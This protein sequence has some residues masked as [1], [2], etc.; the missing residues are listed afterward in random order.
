MAAGRSARLAGRLLKSLSLLE[1][2]RFELLLVLLTPPGRQ[3]AAERAVEKD[4]EEVV[5]FGSG[6]GCVV[7]YATGLLERTNKSLVLTTFRYQNGH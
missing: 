2:F 3:L 6:A 7:D 4:V 1:Q 5:D